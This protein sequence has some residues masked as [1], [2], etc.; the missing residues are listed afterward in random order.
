MQSFN[1]NPYSETTGKGVDRRY[2]R[3][4]SKFDPTQPYENNQNYLYTSKFYGYVEGETEYDLST[5]ETVSNTVYYYIPTTAENGT[6]LNETTYAKDYLNDIKSSF[7]A[8]TAT[9]RSNKAYLV[10]VIASGRDLGN[11]A[12]EWERRGKLIKSHLYYEWRTEEEY[13]NFNTF[14]SSVAANDMYESH[15]K[16]LVYYVAVV[17][18]ADGSTALSNVYTM[19][20]F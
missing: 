15:E 9:P 16:G 17:H 13:D 8:D 5:D 18:F 11:D 1:E 4:Y 20:G 14:D 12:D 10:N 2:G 19:Q 7:F 3:P 6:T